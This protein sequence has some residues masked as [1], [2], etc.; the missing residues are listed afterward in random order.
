MVD[1]VIFSFPASELKE[2][3]D[4]F[5]T[6]SVDYERYG[7]VLAY[8]STD[9]IL[10]LVVDVATSPYSTNCLVGALAY[11][12][13]RNKSKVIKVKKADGFE[14]LSQGHSFKESHELLKTAQSMQLEDKKPT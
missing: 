6:W 7:P 1:K 9:Y 14:F 8:D 4:A 5:S 2:I 13:G 10:Q 11:Y 12:F 3:E